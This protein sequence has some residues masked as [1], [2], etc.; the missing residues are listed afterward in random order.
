MRT[1]SSN[2]IDGPRGGRCALTRQAPRSGGRVALGQALPEANHQ[3]EHTQQ[4]RG[5]AAAAGAA[6]ATA[7]TNADAAASAALVTPNLDEAAW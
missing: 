2:L 3:V 7:A 1:M 6:T 4:Q 5:P